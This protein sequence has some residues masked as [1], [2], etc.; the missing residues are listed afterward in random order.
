MSAFEER[1]FEDLEEGG[2]GSLLGLIGEE[3]DV[4]RHEDI[5]EDEK[6][7]QGA[8]LFE[9]A[10]KGVFGFGGSEEGFAAVAAEGDEVEL[11]GVVDRLRPVGMVV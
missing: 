6:A 3:M 7:L 10:L 1:C 8:G 5:G 11:A 2:Y 9:D 4:L